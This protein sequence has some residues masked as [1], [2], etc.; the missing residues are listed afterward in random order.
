VPLTIDAT[1]ENRLNHVTLAVARLKSGVTL[2]QAKAEM[3]AVSRRV[4]QQFPE[5]KD[6]GVELST[7]P[8]WIV[9]DQLR[10]VLIVLL[11]AVMFV[12]LIACANM[13]N[14][15]L[16]RAAGR[17]QEIAVRL[18]LGA[19]SRRLLRQLLTESTLLSLLGGIAG[20]FA[21]Y[22]VVRAMGTSLPAGLLPVSDV[23]VDST[24]MFFA[25]GISLCTGILFGLAPALQTAKSDLNKILKQGGRSGSAGARP[26]FRKA[27][28][29]SELALA[30]VL[31]VGAGLL[32]QSLF[33]MRAVTLG[34]QPEHLLTFQ[35]SPPAAKYQGPVKT[36]TLYKTV[37]DALQSVPG[38]HGAAVSSGLPFGGGNYNTTP[39]APVGQSKL[40]VGDAIPVDWRLVSPG[41]FQTMEISLLRGRFF[42]EHDDSNSAPVMVISKKTEETLWGSDDP[43]GRTIRIVGSGKQFVV[44]GV[45]GDVRNTALNQEPKEAAYMS[46]AFRQTPLM[47]VVVRTDGTPNSAIAGVRQK[48]R[49][50]DSDL[51]MANVRSMQE[52]ISTSAAQPRLNSVLL[53]IFS[54]VAL[55][56]AAIGIYGVLSYSVNQRTREIGVRVALGAQ[57]SDVVRLVAREGMTIALAGIGAG[58]LAAFAISRVIASLLYGIQAHDLFTFAGVAV[59]LLFVAA[60]ACYLPAIRATR[61]DPIVALR[62]E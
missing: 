44:V 24:V 22:W 21:A 8:K 56:I 40:P 9:G 6:W 7:F 42:D 15:L 33:R 60:I 28:I 41:Y 52:W 19:G 20:V 58:L 35:L 2:A 31:L 17:Q 50:V 53:E 59:V 55:L 13:A 39:M 3:N 25:L 36:W 10:T 12:L 16:A 11:C 49:E 62:Y 46:A 4:G 57:R 45:V 29:A 47:D 23:N 48:L 26:A 54:L 32:M 27:L 51:P 14:L 18:A 43:V 5:V 37:I 34:Y 30:T 1:T 61:I 38:V